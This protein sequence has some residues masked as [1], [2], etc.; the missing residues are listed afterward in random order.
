MTN[1]RYASATSTHLPGS[2]S[3]MIVQTG[4]R[5]QPAP[6]AGLDLVSSSYWQPH[7]GAVALNPQLV[8]E[9]RPVLS[10]EHFDQGEARPSQGGHAL[11]DYQMQLMLLE[12][13][14]K[15][16]LLMARQEQ[17]STDRAAKERELMEVLR[18]PR[19]WA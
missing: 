15:K 4:M 2:R 11:Q 6:Y 17:E 19:D 10:R 7:E 8:V 16:R 5:S 9:S 13:Q 3:S 1:P 14:N 12:Q 18:Q